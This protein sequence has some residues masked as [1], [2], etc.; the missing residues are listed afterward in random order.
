MKYILKLVT[1]VSLLLFVGCASLPTPQEMRD[2][3]VG[4]E[5]PQL[6][7]EGKAMVYV[8]RPAML[9]KLIRFKVFLDNKEAESKMGHTRGKQYIYFEIEP[10]DHQIL[11]KTE[12]TAE[13]K[14]TAEVGD[15]FFIQQEPEIGLFSARNSVMTIPDYQGKY[16]VKHLKLGK[17]YKDK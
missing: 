17:I 1:L 13:I 3:I 11:S 10:G 9:G 8:V 5:L 2:D 14:L 4:F 15:I 7:Q 16:H 12:N 6:P